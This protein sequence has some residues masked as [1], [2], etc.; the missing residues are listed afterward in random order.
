MTIA[1]KGGEGSGSRP[2]AHSS[3]L[4]FNPYSAKLENIVSS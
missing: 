1:L 3:Q 4:I 2:T